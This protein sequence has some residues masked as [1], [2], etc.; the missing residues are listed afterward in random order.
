MA[1]FFEKETKILFFWFFS[2]GRTFGVETI[3]LIFFFNF[4]KFHIFFSQ[5]SFTW[6]KQVL[7]QTKWWILV[8][9]V[10]KLWNWQT[11]LG[12]LTQKGP[13]SRNRA[14][15]HL[16][17]LLGLLVLQHIW[18]SPPQ[19]YPLVFG[20]LDPGFWESILLLLLMLMPLFSMKFS[21][22]SDTS[23]IPLS[24]MSYKGF[25]NTACAPLITALVY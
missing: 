20:N 17:Y 11:V 25:T 12:W 2:K 4:S 13:L 9:P 8:T 21:Y 24:W 14:N 15:C 7:K 1:W 5:N 3:K 10:I 6:T 23:C 18:S 19:L 22:S 16:V